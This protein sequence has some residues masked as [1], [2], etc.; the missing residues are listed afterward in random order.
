MDSTSAIPVTEQRSRGPDLRKISITP[1]NAPGVDSN[2]LDWSFAVEVYLEAAG[3]DYLFKRVELKDRPPSWDRDTKEF[4]SLLVQLVSEPN[5]QSI[6]RFRGDAR[7]MWTALRKDHQDHTSGG[8][9]HW[10]YKLLLSQMDSSDDLPT[11]IKKMRGMYEHFSS[12]ISDEHPLRPDDIFAAALIISLPPDLLPVV[13]PLMSNPLTNSEAVIHA[14]TQ[15]D[16]FFKTRTQVEAPAVQASKTKTKGRQRSSNKSS[17]SSKKPDSHC[18]FCDIDGHDLTTCC[19]SQ[20]ILSGAKAQYNAER[21]ANNTNNCSKNS[22]KAGRVETSSLGPPDSE[23]DDSGNDESTIIFAKSATTA[24]SLSASKPR[25]SNVDSGCSQ[26][27]TPHADQLVSS[28][29]DSTRVRLADDSV[30][31]ATKSGYLWDPAVPGL[32]HRSLLVPDLSEPLLSVSGLSDDGLVTVFNQHNVSLYRQSSF[33]TDSSPVAV[34][35]RRG[36]LYFLPEEV[37][38]SL[39]ASL[40]APV[41]DKSLLEWHRA[42]NHIGLRSLR[43]LLTSLGVRPSVFNDVDVQQCQVCIVFL[44]LQGLVIGLRKRGLSFIQMSVHSRLCLEKVTPTG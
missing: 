30:I 20:R 27:M 15:D 29:P 22:T 12:L 10:L 40:S 41:A 8:R 24:T 25:D 14:L 6:C 17:G 38:S 39:A 9:V 43:K 7:G 23:D 19:T 16:T 42:F 33:K 21:Q 44:L 13:R 4:I 35:N 1:L 5:Y 11:H 31:R 28:R 26:S 32:S 37:R 2:Y 18:T 36:N 3:L 34:G